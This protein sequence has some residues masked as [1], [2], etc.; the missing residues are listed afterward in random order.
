MVLGL[1]RASRAKT[2][3]PC[4]HMKD[5]GDEAS[6]DWSAAGPGVRVANVGARVLVEWAEIGRLSALP[7]TGESTFVPAPGVS[8]AALEKFGAT[9]LLSCLRYFAGRLSLHGAA[10]RLHGGVVAF[11]GDGGAGKST[12]AMALVESLGGDFMTDDA[13]PIDREGGHPIVL[14]VDDKFWLTNETAACFGHS[15][16]EGLKQPVQPR[17][18]ASEA[19]PLSAIVDL[20]FDEAS[21]APE[22]LRLHG[23]ETFLAV[24]RA[25]VSY[26]PS[27]EREAP[28]DLE[29]R[30]WLCATTP[31]FRLSRRRGLDALA[32]TADLIVQSLRAL[33]KTRASDGP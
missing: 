1:P 29:M 24:S 19:A 18:R 14:P 15:V 6:L 26:R 23:L 7:A 8:P 31:V 13:I 16:V 3:D 21:V 12:T 2:G 5:P 4:G 10:V 11:I 28:R 33:R 9:H 32:P 30:A 25:H 27:S 17:A 22:L 20:Q